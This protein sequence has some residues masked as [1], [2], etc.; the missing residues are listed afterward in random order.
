MPLYTV[1]ISQACVRSLGIGN[2]SIFATAVGD[3]RLHLIEVII[4][5]VQ[6]ILEC[7]DLSFGV[8]HVPRAN[9]ILFLAR[10]QY[11]K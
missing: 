7:V 6:R 2:V 9:A 4:F 8:K 3:L 11:Q 5:L 10:L 1:S